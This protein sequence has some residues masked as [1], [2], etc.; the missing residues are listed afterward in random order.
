MDVEAANRLLVTLVI[1]PSLLM[2][3]TSSVVADVDDLIPV[4]FMLVEP[5]TESENNF[6]VKEPVLDRV[7]YLLF[8]EMNHKT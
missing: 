3:R 7:T 8:S 5:I 2:T 1:S 4:A 6:G